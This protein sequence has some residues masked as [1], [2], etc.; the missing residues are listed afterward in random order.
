MSNG[1]LASTV[2]RHEQRLKRLSKSIDAVNNGL[3]IAIKVD[4]RQ[5]LW[6]SIAMLVGM[7]TAAAGVVLCSFLFDV[8]DGQGLWYGVT[9]LVVSTMAIR[10]ALNPIDTQ[11]EALQERLLE[12][13]L[14][15][16]KVREA[17]RDVLLRVEGPKPRTPI[18]VK[19]EAA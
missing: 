19:E 5:A 3:Q 8:W 15:R 2:E 4:H 9:C 18:E 7:P 11:R 16:E 1:L 10:P 6:A 17:L 13:V 14:Q 12:L